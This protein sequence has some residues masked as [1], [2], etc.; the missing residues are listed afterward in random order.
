MLVGTIEALN[1]LGAQ[2][3]CTAACWD[4][5]ARVGDN[6]GALGFAIVAIFA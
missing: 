4:A 2:L 5:L 1:V 3:G 6:F